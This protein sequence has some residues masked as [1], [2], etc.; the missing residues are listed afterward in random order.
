MIKKKF[1]KPAFDKAFKPNYV[2]MPEPELMSAG[3][4][5]QMRDGM[6]HG[7]ALED[8]RLAAIGAQAK[9]EQAEKQAAYERSLMYNPSGAG[10]ATGTGAGMAT[11]GQYPELKPWP[12][13]EV[14][15]YRE[16]KWLTLSEAAKHLKMGPTKFAK[17]RSEGPKYYKLSDGTILYNTHD[18][19]DWV[20]SHGNKEAEI[21]L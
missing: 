9:A 6:A 13:I 4:T 20:M 12:I 15:M 3:E 7:G 8:K 14:P 19:N 10:M 5:Q 2:S 17:M 1:L 21:S 18:V 16:P 11:V